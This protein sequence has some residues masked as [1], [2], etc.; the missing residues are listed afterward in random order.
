[1]HPCSQR[2]GT[3]HTVKDTFSKQKILQ[4]ITVS[5]A[6]LTTV[7]I[8]RVHSTS[9][10]SV[11]W[12]LFHQCSP[13]SCHSTCQYPSILLFSHTR[14]WDKYSVD[15]HTRPDESVHLDPER[16]NKSAKDSCYFHQSKSDGI[17][18]LSQQQQPVLSCHIKSPKLAKSYRT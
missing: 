10:R 15:H 18:S 16:G 7:S 9:M 1:M 17:K 14:P 4:P 5:Q 2:E 3:P 8:L 6:S 13:N 11:A 12:Q